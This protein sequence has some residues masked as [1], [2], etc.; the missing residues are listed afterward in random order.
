MAIYKL[1]LP[2]IK[3]LNTRI[4]VEKDILAMCSLH[5]YHL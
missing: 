3:F 2:S 1:A 5:S 4:A